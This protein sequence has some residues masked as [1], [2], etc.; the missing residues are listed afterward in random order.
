[1]EFSELTTVTKMSGSRV[2]ARQAGPVRPSLQTELACD[3]FLPAYSL[4]LDGDVYRRTNGMRST[5]RIL[6]VERSVSRYIMRPLL[7]F[8]KASV[9]IRSLAPSTTKTAEKWAC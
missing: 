1:M 9:S 7:A 3:P 4:W 8:L 2:T 5:S 6:S